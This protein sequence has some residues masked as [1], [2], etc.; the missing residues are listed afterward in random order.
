LI[1]GRK[2]VR[3]FKIVAVNVAV[4]LLLLLLFEAGLQMIA[5]IFPSYDVLFLQPD[6]VLGWKQVPNHHWTWTGGANWYAS[7]FSVNVETNAL[8]FRDIERALAKAHGVKRVALLGDSFIEAVQVPFKKTAGQLLEH[9][10]V[11]ASTHSRNWE[12]LNFGISNYGVGQY[13]L[14][15]DQY[16][17]RYEPDY[18]AIFV[19]RFHMQRTVRKYE[20][21]AFAA[22]KKS[23]LWVRPTFRLENGELIREPARDFDEFTRVQGDLLKTEFAGQRSRRRKTLIT[24]HYAR[25]FKSRLARLVRRTESRSKIVD[26]DAEAEMFSINRRIIEELGRQVGDVGG[27]LVVVDA[28]RYFGDRESVAAALREVCRENRLG[29]IPLYEHLSKANAEGISTRW[30]DDGHFNEVGNEILAK[31]LF[32]W[33]ARYP[34]LSD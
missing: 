19:A 23:Q 27:R 24:L 12:V 25:E 7:D 20:Y 17:R 1:E 26:A 16:A 2:I 9:A 5:L 31:G 13:L 6:R 33:I 18:V 22:S 4:F 34:P 29:Y 14:T 30:A 10:L 15:W 32:D 21:G 11:A 28:S 3:A 8:G